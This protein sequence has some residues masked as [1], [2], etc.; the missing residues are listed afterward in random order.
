L[1]EIKDQRATES[2]IAMLNDPD[3]DLRDTAQ[4][5]LARIGET[6]IEPLLG[7]VKDSKSQ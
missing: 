6:A 4:D 5:S 1:G 7:A 3:K 2:L